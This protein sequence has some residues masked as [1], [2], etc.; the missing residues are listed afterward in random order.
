MWRQIGVCTPAEISIRN[1]PHNTMPAT[2]NATN[3]N[4]H[5]DMDLFDAIA[6]RADSDA[7][8]TMSCSPVSSP[9][10]ALKPNSIMKRTPSAD[11]VEVPKRTSSFSKPITALKRV[12]SRKF[13]ATRVRFSKALIWEYDS[14]DSEESR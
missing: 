8:S 11:S 7:D 9:M 6:R 5:L 2:S 4:N 12:F 10:S 13:S 3:N 14:S 1:Y